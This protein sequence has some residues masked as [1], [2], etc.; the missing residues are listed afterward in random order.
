MPLIRLLPKSLFNAHFCFKPS[1]SLSCFTRSPQVS[2]LAS[3]FSLSQVSTGQNPILYAMALKMPN[4]LNR[5]CFTTWKIWSANIDW[6]ARQGIHRRLYR[7][8]FTNFYLLFSCS[9]KTIIC[10]ILTKLLGI[11]V[12]T[13][14]TLGPLLAE[15]T[16]SGRFVAL[17]WFCRASRGFVA[18][19]WFCRASVVLS[20]FR[21]FVALPWFCRAS[22]LLSR[23][24]KQ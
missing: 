4:H 10:F 23:M 6:S 8:A 3:H 2:L 22:V 9:L 21:G 5:P 7:S 19:P 17:P 16:W 11:S 1:K 20:R 15:F 13:I 24:F 12:C 18:L 14:A